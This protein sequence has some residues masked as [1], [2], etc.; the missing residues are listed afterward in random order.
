MIVEIIP[1]LRLPRNLNRFSYLV[2]EELAGLVKVGQIIE[3]DFRGRKA[4]GLI[5]EIRDGRQETRKLKL[6][7]IRK[8]IFPA[9][10]ITSAQ[11]DLIKK[12]AKYYGISEGIVCR[13]FL[14]TIPKRGLKIQEYKIIKIKAAK[15]TNSRLF[16]WNTL[17]ERDEEYKKIIS[18]TKG[19]ILILTPQIDF[20]DQL[21]KNLK[22]DEKKVIK[23]HN[24]IKPKEFFENWLK[25]LSG[26][27]QII[28]GTK[29]A[30][31]LP[32]SNLK[33]I[34]IDEEQDWNHKQ[35]DINPRYDARTVAEWLA[36]TSG[37]KLILASAAPRVETYFR[38]C[39][40]ERS[41]ES[42]KNKLR[43]F[44]VP[45][46]AGGS[47]LLRMTIVSLN[48]E[49]TKGNYSLLSDLLKEKIAETLKTNKK[50]FLFHNRKGAA[51]FVSC[52]DCGHVF[53][54]PECQ[55]SLNYFQEQQKMK[56][57]HCAH[58]E[59]IPPLCPKCSGPN[60]TFK[61]KGVEDLALELKKNFP[62]IS[63]TAVFQEKK[64]IYTLDKIQIIAG[65]EFAL[66]K[67]NWDQIGLAA[68]IN[69]DQ[70]VNRPDFG[71][72]KNAYNLLKN[73]QTKTS[74]EFIVQ[75]HNPDNPILKSIKENQPEI[76]YEAELENRQDLNYPPFFRLIKIIFQD[77][78]KP[79]AYYLS[80][81]L[82][83]EIKK[84][85]KNW[86]VKGPLPAVPE[87]I[88]G[89]FFYH[90]IVKLPLTSNLDELFKIIPPDFVVDVD[91]EKLT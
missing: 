31:S 19:Q 26:K 75:A 24:G 77:K 74:G 46:P 42:C 45:P 29:M 39:H 40:S 90:V 55:I 41:E 52:S 72:Q 65:T 80:D 86:Q 15:I 85:D 71:A 14:P 59:E 12:V 17:Q 6:K 57:G 61:S 16:W 28:I 76:F 44:V 62:E 79:R 49:H 51:G 11:I 37:A 69:F 33:T 53:K 38:Q 78:S 56:C 66:N 50:I 22:L 10:L 4:E 20:V 36:E 35:S 47:G 89:N 27:P 34:I 84:L 18:K 1:A 25:I 23:I 21:I 82:A 70:L 3:V 67:I 5:I 81:Q 88:R 73:I 60:I 58:Q 9:P 2:P 13:S 91:P 7:P 32:F 83:R 54:C 64:K 43:S 87:K 8:I 30:I 68:V 63:I 48:D